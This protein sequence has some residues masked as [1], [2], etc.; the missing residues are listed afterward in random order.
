[1]KSLLIFTSMI[2]L[3]AA[4]IFPTVM[5]YLMCFMLALITF[6]RVTG[7]LGILFGN[8]TPMPSEWDS[9]KIQWAYTVATIAAA[10]ALWVSGSVIA[11]WIVVA[12]IP[13]AFVAA[14]FLV[15]STM[16]RMAEQNAD[17]DSGV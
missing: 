2:L 11:Y 14:Y 13:M 9:I 3:Y 7:M 10:Y 4:G 8:V 12:F 1:L 6:A 15:Q 5:L 17:T 16:F